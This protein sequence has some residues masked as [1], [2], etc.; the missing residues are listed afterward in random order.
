MLSVEKPRGLPADLGDTELNEAAPAQPT[1]SRG[2][3]VT[4]FMNRSCLRATSEAEWHFGH[5]SFH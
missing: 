1:G 4:P 2:C 3:A 5:T